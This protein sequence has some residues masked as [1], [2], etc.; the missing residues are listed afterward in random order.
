MRSFTGVSVRRL[1]NGGS[2]FNAIGSRESSLR[3]A[4][5]ILILRYCACATLAQ[6]FDSDRFGDNIESARCV[7]RERRELGI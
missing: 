7:R 4:C 6:R 2:T 5:N 3:G 1:R